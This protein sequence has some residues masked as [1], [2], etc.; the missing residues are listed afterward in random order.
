PGH[1]RTRFVCISDT[2]NQQ[3]ALPKGDVLIHAGDLTNQGSYSEL[4]KAVSWLQKQE[5]E[6]KI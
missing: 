1:R 3:V 2:H 4:Q 6:V 5:F